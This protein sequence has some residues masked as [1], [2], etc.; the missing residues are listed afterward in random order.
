MKTPQGPDVFRR[1]CECLHRL[2]TAAANVN[3]PFPASGKR[4]SEFTLIELLLVIAIIAIL[5]SILL[6]ALS[7]VREL[8]FGVK[9]MNN[10]KQ[11]GL[12]LTLYAESYRDWSLGRSTPYFYQTAKRDAWSYLFLKDNVLASAVTP[13][14]NAK[15]IQTQLFCNIAN[16]KAPS[17]LN[18]PGSGYYTI[19]NELCNGNNDRKMY[20]WQC[21][22]RTESAY[23]SFFKPY[24]VK[25]PHRLYWSKCSSNYEDNVYRFWHSGSTQLL[26]V[27]MT[28]RKLPRQEVAPSSGNY[29]TI[30]TH[31]PANGSPLLRYYE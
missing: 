31:Y 11:L 8:A 23:R 10:Q 28:V 13:F 24:T 16:A 1:R 2:P 25:L 27:D 17:S 12:S 22:S 5:A 18:N 29:T 6:P 3:I 4:K 9:C 26:F 15:A 14:P 19:N 7:R 20:G 30:W 21:D